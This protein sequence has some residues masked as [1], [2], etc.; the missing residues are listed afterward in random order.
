M[1]K[2]IR[3]ALLLCAMTVCSTSVMAT[4]AC[5]VVICMYG[6]TTGNNGGNEFHSAERTFFNIVKK[7]KRGFLPDHTADARKS[8]LF[9]CDS[10][11]PAI[12]TQIINKFGRMCG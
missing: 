2:T 7:N 1:K 8:F 12:I 9:E 5:E 11:D 4:D 10:A 6:K 3:S